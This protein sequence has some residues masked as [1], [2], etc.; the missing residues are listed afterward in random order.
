MTQQ[1][2]SKSKAEL[3]K[4]LEKLQGGFSSE[5]QKLTVPQ[6]K[7]KIAAL[8]PSSSPS[9]DPETPAVPP[10]EGEEAPRASRNEGFDVPGKLNHEPFDKGGKAEA[11]Y[12]AFCEAPKK[13]TFIPLEPSDVPGEYSSIEQFTF[14]RLR[15]NMVKGVSVEVPEPLALHIEEMQAARRR[16]ARPKTRDLI[17][18]GMRDAR[19]D[20]L[21]DSQKL[22]IL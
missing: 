18:G 6:L 3:R 22:G 4:E 13:A 16:A 8:E 2:K 9:L 5:D 21:S 19:L 17:R 7:E 1:K 15:I 20:L 11:T 10:K 12:K 14:N